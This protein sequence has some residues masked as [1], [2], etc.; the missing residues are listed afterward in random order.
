MPDILH[1]NSQVIV[2]PWSTFIKIYYARVRLMTSKDSLYIHRLH[3]TLDHTIFSPCKRTSSWN[4][5]T[6]DS[7]IQHL[8][9]NRW[10]LTYSNISTL[11]HNPPVNYYLLPIPIWLQGENHQQNVHP[12]SSSLYKVHCFLTFS[13]ITLIVHYISWPIH[14]SKIHANRFK[15]LTS[16]LNIVP[17]LEVPE[18]E[19]DKC[20]Y[21]THLK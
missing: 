11:L 14:S 9:I 19:T 21:I 8:E 16:E 10:L 5:N 2:L 4:H 20:N 3:V 6:H 7:T 1:C 17:N 12:P 15:S 18:S 13:R